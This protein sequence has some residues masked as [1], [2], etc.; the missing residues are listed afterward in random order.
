MAHLPMS[1]A[2]VGAHFDAAFL[3]QVSPAVLNQA[4]QTVAGAKLSWIQVSELNTVVAIVSPGGA[5]PAGSG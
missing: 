5:R 2:Q 3:A 1:G 4:L